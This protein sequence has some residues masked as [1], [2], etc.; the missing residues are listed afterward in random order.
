MAADILLVLIN[1]SKCLISSF[2]RQVLS[3]DVKL[4]SSPF[5]DKA[6]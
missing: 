5:K 6:R 3:F 1:L 4:D 2:S